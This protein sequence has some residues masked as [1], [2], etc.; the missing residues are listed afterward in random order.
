[1]H[2]GRMGTRDCHRGDRAGDT[3]TDDQG[4]AGGSH[5]CCLC[6]VVAS[7]V[8]ACSAWNWFHGWNHSGLLIC[9]GEPLDERGVGVEQGEPVV[10]LDEKQ[11]VHAL[12]ERAVDQLAAP[13]LTTN[14]DVHKFL[15]TCMNRS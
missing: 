11:R 7:W 12:G 2:T 9:F 6:W 8:V 13:P 14:E 1:M 4:S 15:L 10:L 5:G 3:A